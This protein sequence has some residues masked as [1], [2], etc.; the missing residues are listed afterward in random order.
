[1]QEELESYLAR[2]LGLL[3]ADKLDKDQLRAKEIIIKEIE[4]YFK[5]RYDK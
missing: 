5:K 2:A 1:M 3:K 4:T